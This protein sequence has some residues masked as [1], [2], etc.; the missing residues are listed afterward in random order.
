IEFEGTYPLPEAQQDRFL[1][2]L[3]IDFPTFEEE[4][5]VLKNVIENNFKS[6][7]VEP[8]LDIAE[9]LKARQEIEQ[10]TV[11]DSVLEY[12]MQIVR[13]TRETEAIRFGASTRAAISIGKAAQA[14]A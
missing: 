5:D 13:R 10:V 11:N 7:A 1:F 9:F 8:V 4:K 3:M 14:W 6:T 12:I 2:K